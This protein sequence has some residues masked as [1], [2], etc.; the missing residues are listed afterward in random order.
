[1]G[2]GEDASPSRWRLYLEAR[3]TLVQTLA[4]AL[5]LSHLLKNGQR[6]AKRTRVKR[7]DRPL[8]TLQCI[9]ILSKLG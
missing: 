4:P 9:R 2:L 8:H 6:I 1:M 5:K 3:D 7:P